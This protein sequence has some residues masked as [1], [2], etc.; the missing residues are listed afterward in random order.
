MAGGYPYSCKE[1]NSAEKKKAYDKEAQSSYNK[2]YYQQNHDKL[3][4]KRFREKYS[5]TLDDFWDLLEAQEY[6]CKICGTKFPN[7]TTAPVVD[8]DH[9]TGVVRGLLCHGC[10][11]GL[12]RFKDN[13]DV[14]AAAI[15]YLNDTQTA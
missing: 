6:C 7:T 8:H 1:C 13:V 3:R 9:E 10:N 15:K 2:Q 11:V 12:G 4:D 5:I 14:L